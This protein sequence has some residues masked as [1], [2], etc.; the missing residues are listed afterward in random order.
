MSIAMQPLPVE[1]HR[2]H[3]R[4]R[5]LAPLELVLWLP[6]LLFVAA[7]MV[8]F[9]TMAAWRVRGEI[10]SRDAAWRVR[11]PRTGQGENRPLDKVWPDPA[12]MRVETAAGVDGLDDPSIQQPVVRGPLDNG[13]GVNN[14]LNPASSQIAFR[15]VTSIEKQYPLMTSLGSYRSGDIQHFLTDGTWRIAQMGAANYSRRSFLLYELPETD[16]SLPDAFAS[17]VDAITNMPLYAALSV[18][19]DDQEFLKYRGFTPDFHPT[20]NTNMQE[21]DRQVIYDTVVVP[22]IDGVD[23]RDRVVLGRISRLPQ[24]MTRSFLNMY[25]AEIAE[26]EQLIQTL[27]DMQDDPATPAATLAQIPQQIAAAEAIIAEIE[28]KVEQLEEYSRRLGTIAAQQAQAAREWSDA[29]GIPLP[30]K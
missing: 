27:E 12:V 14:R 21:L 11:W 1:A 17:S 7:L 28:P 25:N 3:R 20:I 22:L 2:G 13:W 19:D 5:G 18:L 8:N 9:G 10:V 4:R 24:T 26:Q 23:S 15:G 30:P 6:V 29:T 16:Q